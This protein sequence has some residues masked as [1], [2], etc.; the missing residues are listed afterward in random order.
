MCD[1]GKHFAQYIIKNYSLR[2]TNIFTFVTT[3][4]S[5]ILREQFL[6]FRGSSRWSWNISLNEYDKEKVHNFILSRLL[7]ICSKNVFKKKEKSNTYV[8]FQSYSYFYS[9]ID[10]YSRIFLSHIFFIPNVNIDYISI[11]KITRS[12]IAQ[13][14]ID[15]LAIQIKLSFIWKILANL[16]STSLL[17]QLG[18]LYNKL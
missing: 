13:K 15:I 7:N 14:N 18:P 10:L 12:K 11:V 17:T 6:L 9:S 8:K 4:K 3:H 2:L 1:T 5:L 16:V